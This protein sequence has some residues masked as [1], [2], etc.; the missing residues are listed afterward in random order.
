MQNTTGD[1]VEEQVS[2]FLTFGMGAYSSTILSSQTV[3]MIGSLLCAI[4]SSSSS[5]YRT[6]FHGSPLSKTFNMPQAMKSD[7]E[8]ETLASDLRQCIDG[9]SVGWSGEKCLQGAGIAGG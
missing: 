6:I 3:L 9:L 1:D 4:I 2:L 7:K 8:K 5:P